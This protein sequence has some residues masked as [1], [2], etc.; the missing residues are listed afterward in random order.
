V[1]A[2]VEAVREFAEAGFD[3]VALIQA[4]GDQQEPFL[5]RAEKTL[6][7]ALRDAF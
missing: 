2:F 4:G 1:D 7:P 5:D 6:L 3:E